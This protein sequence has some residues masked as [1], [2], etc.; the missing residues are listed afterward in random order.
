MKKRQAKKK[1]KIDS[2]LKL[3]IIEFFCYS[4]TILLIGLALFHE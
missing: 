2:V 4:V 3:R 1:I